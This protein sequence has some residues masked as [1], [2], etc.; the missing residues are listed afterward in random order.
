MNA[1]ATRFTPAVLINAAQ[2]KYSVV[3]AERFYTVPAILSQTDRD[4][5]LHR[6]PGQ[7]PRIDLVSFVCGDRPTEIKVL[8]R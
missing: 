4:T 3:S 2:S 6:S 1:C 7:W 5:C 8:A